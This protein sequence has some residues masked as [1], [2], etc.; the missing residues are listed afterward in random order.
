MGPAV[1]P[2]DSRRG[3]RA[4]GLHDAGGVWEAREALP[5]VDGGVMGS[6]A[7]AQG[8]RRR[9]RAL[10]PLPLH[11]PSGA[12][13][14][15]DTPVQG[16]P[17]LGT[18]LHLCPHHAARQP[19]AIPGSL[20]QSIAIPPRPSFSGLNFSRFAFAIPTPAG[21]GLGTAKLPRP[22]SVL[23][24]RGWRGM[25]GGEIHTI[26]YPCLPCLSTAQSRPIIPIE[27]HNCGPPD[28]GVRQRPSIMFLFNLGEPLDLVSLVP[29]SHQS[30]NNTSNPASNHSP[31]TIPDLPQQ[32]P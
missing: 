13:P 29:L 27:L 20:V 28:G 22:M 30:I 1:R 24:G 18:S 17:L 15:T 12:P 14:G 9:L 26:P 2:Q 23:W 21:T 32:C 31:S 10:P 16:T 6:M 4:P 3:S 19:G 8:R 5:R 11:P 7:S 25:D